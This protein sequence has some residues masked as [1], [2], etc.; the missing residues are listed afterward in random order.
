MHVHKPIILTWSRMARIHHKNAG[1]RNILLRSQP[2]RDA[3]HLAGFDPG[4]RAQQFDEGCNP[5]EMGELFGVHDKDLAI[6]LQFG[7]QASQ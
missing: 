3:L 2:Q 1:Q 5:V 4:D 7:C 6:H